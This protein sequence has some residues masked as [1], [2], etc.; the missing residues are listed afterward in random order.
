MG[1][2]NPSAAAADKH[3]VAPSRKPVFL[4]LNAFFELIG[5]RVDLPPN[6]VAGRAL[7]KWVVGGDRQ[8]HASTR[9]LHSTI[10]ALCPA[11]SCNACRL[12]VHNLP[13]WPM[14]A[15]ALQLHFQALQVS[16]II[17]LRTHR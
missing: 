10:A 9:T 2:D 16:F 1:K 5:R 6:K 7:S 11:E 14:L 12:Q 3:S 17:N 15:V 4:F 8:T 13:R